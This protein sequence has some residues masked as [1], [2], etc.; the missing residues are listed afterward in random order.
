MKGIP[1]LK[2]FKALFRYKMKKHNISEDTL[3]KGLGMAQYAGTQEDENI[4]KIYFLTNRKLYEL[5]Y[6][7]VNTHDENGKPLPKDQW[8]VYL[9]GSLKELPLRGS[10]VM[11]MTRLVEQARAVVVALS[12]PQ[13]GTSLAETIRV[14]V[15]GG[16]LP[17]PLAF[18]VP[19]IT[20]TKDEGHDRVEQRADEDEFEEAAQTAHMSSRALSIRNERN[21]RYYDV[22]EVS[23]TWGED[24]EPV[25]HL[26]YKQAEAYALSLDKD[27][28]ALVLRYYAELVVPPGKKRDSLEWLNPFSDMQQELVAS[29]PAGFFFRGLYFETDAVITIESE[30]GNE[31]V[32]AEFYLATAFRVEREEGIRDLNIYRPF[33]RHSEAIAWLNT[34]T[35]TKASVTR[36]MP[37][38]G[39]TNW[40]VLSDGQ[41][42]NPLGFRQVGEVEWL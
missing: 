5:A 39:S 22:I 31:S 37:D 8:M 41:N 19:S 23:P 40:F 16:E 17:L 12:L 10:E 33:G 25:K 36:L 9:I 18:I 28:G 13:M 3:Q 42:L 21:M 32:P 20:V 38:P 29:T 2:L 6:R 34:I 30:Q 7:W 26:P 14:E 27:E 15:S 24:V 35:H 1:T 4:L 11:K